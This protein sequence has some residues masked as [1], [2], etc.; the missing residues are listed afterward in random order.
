MKRH[1]SISQEEVSVAIQQF[2]S[3][4]GLIER[5]PIQE[6]KNSKVIGEEKYEIYE[7][8]ANLAGLQA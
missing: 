6:N 5:L 3:K 8:F 4:G 7:S 1:D 2:L